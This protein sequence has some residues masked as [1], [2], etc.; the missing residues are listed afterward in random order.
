MTEKRRS[1]F[2]H[3]LEERS[4]MDFTENNIRN[5]ILNVINSY[6]ETI[7][8]S[9]LDLFDRFTIESS[10]SGSLYEKNIHYY[11]GWKTNKSYKIGKKI[12]VNIFSRYQSAFFAYNSWTLSFEAE[13]FLNDVDKV[14]NYFD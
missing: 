1:E 7:M 9:V 12:V 6:E 13:R 4:Y 8:S 10:F 5:F 14:M 11:N 3:L 2:Q